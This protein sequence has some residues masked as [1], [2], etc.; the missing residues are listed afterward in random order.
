[1]D[2]LWLSAVVFLCA[3]LASAK[4][5]GS[6][7]P[8][9]GLSTL[10]VDRILGS[11]ADHMNTLCPSETVPISCTCEFGFRDKIRPTGTAGA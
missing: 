10:E 8:I 5:P 6:L 4:P 2:G 11:Y 3:T 9:P 1:M 7:T